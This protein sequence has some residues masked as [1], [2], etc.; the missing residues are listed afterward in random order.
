[1][2]KELIYENTEESRTGYF[3]DSDAY[4]NMEELGLAD[5]MVEVSGTID[6]TLTEFD[7]NPRGFNTFSEALRV[8]LTDEI[9]TRVFLYGDKLIIETMTQETRNRFNVSFFDKDN[10][11][12]KLS[13]M[14]M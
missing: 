2:K 11:K 7:V 14:L 9:E 5:S 1:M 6:N 10:N 12:I 8:M 4:T 13:E 3:I